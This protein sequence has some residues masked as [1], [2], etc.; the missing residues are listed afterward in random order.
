MRS[1]TAR[2]ILI[3]AS[4]AVI[5]LSTSAALAG[6]SRVL[7]PRKG[8][9]PQGAWNAVKARAASDMGSARVK[10]YKSG[11]SKGLSRGLQGKLGS[12]SQA[13]VVHAKARSKVASYEKKRGPY[14]AVKSHQGIW[15]VFPLALAANK[16][17]RPD[18]GNHITRAD[19]ARSTNN[20]Y[21]FADGWIPG[22]KVVQAVKAKNTVWT[23]TSE[24]QIVASKGKGRNKTLFIL[25]DPNRQSGD[26]AA[27][28]T[29]K[30]HSFSLPP[31]HRPTPL[32]R[33]LARGAGATQPE[34]CIIPPNF[35]GSTLRTK[36][37]DVP[38]PLHR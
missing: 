9:V 14:L 12:F 4:M 29:V 6:K 15:E 5:V 13:Y 36:F 1:I 18:K 31:T 35:A 28:A 16:Q 27:Y 11:W 20:T 30:L 25:G 21:A 17:G 32:P 3:V 34:I 38:K 7:A 33:P 24:G 26:P 22:S 8:W 10:L 37:I 19:G 23:S 2:N